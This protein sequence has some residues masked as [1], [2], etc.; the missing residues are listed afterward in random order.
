MLKLLFGVIVEV[1]IGVSLAGIIL[2]LVIPG[3]SLFDAAGQRDSTATIIIVGVLAA[4]L[5][6]ALFRPGSAIRR[7]GRR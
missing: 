6:V 4:A 1:I 3:L 2:A 7:Y 5:A